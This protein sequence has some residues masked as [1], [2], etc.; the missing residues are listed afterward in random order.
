M[1]AVHACPQLTP[2][3]RRELAARGIHYREG[4]CARCAAPIAYQSTPL[5]LRC[6]E[7]CAERLLR[8][9]VHSPVAIVVMPKGTP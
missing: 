1:T 6:C 3:V 9:E 4:V 5:A 8:P 7:T 2:A